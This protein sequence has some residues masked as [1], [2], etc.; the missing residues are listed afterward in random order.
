MEGTTSP[1]SVITNT[2][3]AT[4]NTNDPNSGNDCASTQTTVAAPPNGTVRGTKFDDRNRDGIRDADGAD[5]IAGNADDEVGLEDWTIVV[6]RD[7]DGDGMLSQAERSAGTYTGGLTL[8]D[9]SYA[10]SL[11][12][13][14]YIVVEV[15][16]PDWVQTAPPGRGGSCLGERRLVGPPRLCGFRHIRRRDCGP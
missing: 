8:A 7:T 12:P 6:Y 11:P 9:G 14:D 3:C 4:S 10:F 5:D 1:G 2:S 15:L 16:Q 13:D